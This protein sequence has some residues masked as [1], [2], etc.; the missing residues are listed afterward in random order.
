[1]E[2]AAEW[3]ATRFENE[4]RVK[5]GGSIPPLS[6]AHTK[7]KLMED[8]AHGR[9]ASLEIWSRVKPGGIIQY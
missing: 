1:M 4:S 5:P 6:V 7:G 2:G 8:N 9:A 3:S